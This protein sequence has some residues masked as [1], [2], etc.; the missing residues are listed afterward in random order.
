M[1]ETIIL[2]V[3]I[4]GAEALE[5]LN[6]EIAKL[7]E[8]VKQLDKERKEGTKTEAEYIK[9][10]AKANQ[11]IREQQAAAADMRKELKRQTQESKEATGSLTQM[12]SELAKMKKEYANLS[13]VQ[14]EGAVGKDL[15][16]RTKALNDEVSAIEQGIGVFSRN[17]GN[18]AASV[19]DALSNMAGSLQLTS[20]N[21]TKMTG[22]VG[23]AGNAFKSM[24]TAMNGVPIL[25]FMQL[26][27]QLGNVLGEFDGALDPIE[28]ALGGLRAALNPLLTWVKDLATNLF[29]LFGNMK[30]AIVA[31][32][33]AM[34]KVATGDF[35]AAQL[36][37]NKASAAM[38]KVGS[39]MQN[40][41]PS[42]D[43]LTDAMAKQ[44]EMGKRLVAMQQDL[45]DQIAMLAVTQT[46]ATK[47]IEQ[48]EA[49]A[50]D[51]TLSLIEREKALNE[52]K[53]EKLAL[54]A[55]EDKVASARARGI[56]NEIL[57][58]NKLN[59]QI[60]EN[61]NFTTANIEAII[62]QV[63]QMKN[64]P[65][66]LK[67]E[68]G[69]TIEQLNEALKLQQEAEES[70][71]DIT[72][73]YAAKS[74]KIR[75]ALAEE[76]A[77]RVKAQQ[78]QYKRIKE[79]EIEVETD[80]EVRLQKRIAMVRYEL[81]L[82]KKATKSK[83]ERALLTKKANQEIAKLEQ[84]YQKAQADAQAK[85]AE[86]VSQAAAN[87]AALAKT[88]A[89]RELAA[90]EEQTKR[91]NL[92][93]TEAQAAG[94]IN[95]Q[96]AN[97]QR[98]TIEQQH[99]MELLRLQ[100]Q[101]GKD[102]MATRERIAQSKIA[103]GKAETDAMLK[104]QQAQV[105][106]AKSTVNAIASAA[107][108]LMGNSAAGQEFAKI[109][110]L[111]QIAIDTATAI[112]GITRIAATTSPDPI[113]FAVQLTAGI[114]QV[115]ANIA[116][117]TQIVGSI[118]QSQAPTLQRARSGGMIGGNLHANGGTNIN[119][120]QGEVIINRAAAAQY[121]PVLEAINMSTG[122]AG[123]GIAPI[124]RQ[125]AQDATVSTTFS[126]AAKG[127]RPIVNVRDIARVTSETV[128]VKNAASL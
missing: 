71:L 116:R 38:A 101:Y 58:A 122:G 61:T 39:G 76:Q 24:G 113:T 88:I 64:T 70:S 57:L 104:Q 78:E 47:K 45:D 117:A 31:F 103:S 82:D 27:M 17:V 124:Q 107:E 84:E 56:V 114:A 125:M 34:L 94:A 49:R 62:K 109:A 1:E 19:K 36:E 20:G 77:Q 53:R 93:V 14:R 25:M 2:D 65:G 110:A 121:A 69:K 51:K 30:D 128:D 10:A 112:G 66:A 95:Q 67:G 54:S 46:I 4:P 15:K 79:L 11:Q 29:G 13:K 59:N 68:F 33:K 75:K 73:E 37:F 123:F 50:A 60:K 55:E 111:A 16:A 42:V 92:L 90:L 32:G 21:L 3:Q 52:A 126:N 99:L 6:L 12:R 43:G 9:E 18:Y 106:I 119:A 127:I 81:E 85:A 5:A 118:G 115:A 28:Q 35:E 89:D 44:Y 91:R 102:T 72:L 26:F 40:L 41:V 98:L 108:V 87:D 8:Q 97:A 22:S 86:Q 63:D 105:A 80:E 100:E 96:E 120:E 48:A 83:V 7:K 23:P 74:S